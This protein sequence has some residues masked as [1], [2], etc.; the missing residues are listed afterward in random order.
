MSI[1]NLHKRNSKGHIVE[2]ILTVCGKK[3]LVNT[4]QQGALLAKNHYDIELPDRTA[5]VVELVVAVHMED[6]EGSVDLV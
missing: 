6:M 5:W 2:I 4:K 1:Q 3:K